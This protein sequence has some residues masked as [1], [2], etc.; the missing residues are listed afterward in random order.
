MIDY[1]KLELAHQLC[2]KLNGV[3][4]ADFIMS[5]YHC[6]YTISNSK[7]PIESNPFFITESLDEFIEKLW[8]FVDVPVAKYKIGQEVWRLN[9]EY[10]PCSFVISDIEESSRY[11]SSK[12]SEGSW[13]I[14]KHLY[15]SE[16]S[17]WIEELLYPS[18]EELIE[19]QI[20]YWRNLQLKEQLTLSDI[21]S[22][23]N[24]P[25]T[26]YQH[27]KVECEHKDDG[28]MY[29]KNVP[30]ESSLTTIAKGNGMCKCIECGEF[31]R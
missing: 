25:I 26:A 30:G 14:G 9:E 3:I 12:G 19:T 13:W 27:E 16:G 28:G 24:I 18:R 6:E 15:S 20:E 5:A 23:T 11:F 21:G 4:Y 7:G 1:K 22:E 31:Y 17:W 29:F 8:K 2:Q 10:E